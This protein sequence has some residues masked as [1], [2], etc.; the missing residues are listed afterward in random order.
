M[1]AQAGISASQ[2]IRPKK[3]NKGID[4]RRTIELHDMGL[5]APLFAKIQGCDPS[6]ITRVLQRYGAKEVQTTEFKNHRAEILAGLQERILSC[7]TDKEIKKAAFGTK[8]VTAGILYDKERLERGQATS[9]NVEVLLD[10]LEAIRSSR[11]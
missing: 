9:I 7:I 1:K 11:R 8:I 6:N 5:E 2:A 10:V 4:H 3:A